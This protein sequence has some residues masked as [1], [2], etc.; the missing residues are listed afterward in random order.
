MML[1]LR[2]GNENH[3]HYDS[4]LGQQ[5]SWF[6]CTNSSQHLSLYPLN[7]LTHTVKSL[8][9]QSYSS[10]RLGFLSTPGIWRNPNHGFVSHV[11]GIRE[12]AQ[13][14]VFGL[15]C[16]SL[17]WSHD[18]APPVW[19]ITQKSLRKITVF[20]LCF[21]PKHLKKANNFNRRISSLLLDSITLL[22]P[23]FDLHH[24]S[25]KILLSTH[26]L[27]TTVIAEQ[28]NQNSQVTQK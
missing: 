10:R 22:D 24:L 18:L 2:K 27:R 8:C 3:P 21:A 6:M 15:F 23:T 14:T 20:L 28:T 12:V 11:R 26:V 19:Q 17:S 9:D 5:K 25:M 16:I 7:E 13:L 1:G 4:C